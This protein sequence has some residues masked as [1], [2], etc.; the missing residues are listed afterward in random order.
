[1]KVLLSLVS[2]AVLLASCAD[3]PPTTEQAQQPALFPDYNHA[4]YPD[5]ISAAAGIGMP[6]LLQQGFCTSDSISVNDTTLTLTTRAG[7]AQVY[8]TYEHYINPSDAP[9]GLS[10]YLE[11]SSYTA[12]GVGQ[13]AAVWPRRMPNAF[14][15]SRKNTFNATFDC[16][17]YG[18]RVL[19]AVGD[20]SV[21]GNAYRN[22]QQSTRSRGDSFAAHGWVASAYQFAVSFPLVPAATSGWQYI[23]GGLD[24][25]SINYYAKLKNRNARPYA[26][27][28]RPWFDS[29]R[30]GD[31]LSFGYGPTAH[32]NGHF[33][34]IARAPSLL[35]PDSLTNGYLRNKFPDTVQKLA[36]KYAIYAVDVFDCSGEYAHFND[37][38][39]NRSGIG[40]GTLLMLTS[41]SDHTPMGFV[42]GP[43]YL[44][45]SAA[46]KQELVGVGVYAISVGRWQPADR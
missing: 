42:F 29:A 16:V 32:D 7:A 2:A 43:N 9:S 30:A 20:S 33:M 8:L 22:L 34:V 21:T 39:H 23:S 5:V 35:T 10:Y 14:Y 18:T 19:S 28:A 24:V 12:Y 38:R 3:A 46:I 44:K 45:D 27:K 25:D 1:M 6:F 40:H 41:L 31:I 4:F 17:G 37:S 26:G 15:D 36:R 11:S 13:Y